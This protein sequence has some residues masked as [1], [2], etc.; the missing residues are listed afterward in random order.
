MVKRLEAEVWIHDNCAGC[1]LCVSACSK[2]VLSW[3]GGSHPVLRRP[4][5]TVGYTKGTLDS[6]TFCPKFCEE[7]CPR[8]E[9]L[10]PLETKVVQAAKAN[11]PVKTGTPNGVILSILA[12][13]RSAGLIDGV[14]MH[15]FDPWKL[16]PIVRVASTVEEI[17]DSIGPQYLWAPTLGV[18]NEAIFD[19]GMKNLAVVGTPCVAQAIRKLKNSTNPRLKPYQDAIRLVISVFCTG[20]YRPELIEEEVLKKMGIA[21]DSIRRLEVSIK[22]D[23]L[24]VMLWDGSERIIER[25]QA[26]SYTRSGCGSCDDFLGTSADIAVGNLGTAEDA[27]TLLIYTRTGDVFTRNAIKMHLINTTDK[28][29]LKALKVA[30]GEKS[31]RERAQAFQDIRVLM[32][33]ALVDP[34]KRGEAIQ[35]FVRLYRTPVSSKPQEIVRNSCTGC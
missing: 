5:K 18:L 35:Q 31:R 17:V 14:L 22:Q 10:A 3:N 23:A 25:Q 16:E 7:V 32:L 30:A 29:D 1:G 8:L 2:L 19:W 6:C 33:D 20:I 28:V 4:I 15:D 9:H 27:S 11:G 34:L 24:K 21:P 26:E 13:G 12:A